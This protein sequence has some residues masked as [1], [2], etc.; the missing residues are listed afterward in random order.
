MTASEAQGSRGALSAWLE[1]LLVRELAA[2]WDQINWALFGEAMHRPIFEL[3]DTT[4]LLGSWRAKERT[5]AISREA[6]TT[7]PWAE[8]IETIKHEA[9]HQYVDEVLGGDATPHG[10]RFREV[11]HARALLAKRN[12]VLTATIDAAAAQA[13]AQAKAHAVITVLV[14]RGLAPAPGQR[15]AILAV[16]DPEAQ[17]RLLIASATCTDVERLLADAARAP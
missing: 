3:A 14:A 15:A 13:A 11:C 12:A 17:E 10:P 2:E 6:A 16:R 4:A 8:T 7:R 9:A 1:T 5:I